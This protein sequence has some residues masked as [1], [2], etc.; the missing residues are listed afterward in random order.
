MKIL[1]VITKSELGGAQSV[2]TNISNYL[3]REHEVTVVAGEGDGRMFDE[4]APNI[5][6]VRCETLVRA[7]SPIKEVKT[8]MFLRKLYRDFR[9]DIIHLHSSK[10]GILG[11]IIFPSAK[12]VYTVHGFDSVRLAFRQFLPVERALR[13]ACKYVVG[14][15]RYDCNNLKAEGIDHNVH[16]VYNG[17]KDCSEGEAQLPFSVPE[18]YQKK[19]VCIARLSPQ[20]N[21]AIFLEVARRMPDVA[22]IW[23]GNLQEAPAH[24]DNVFFWGNIPYSGRL[25]RYFDLFFLPTNYEGLPIVILEAMS[26]GLPVVASDVGGVHEIVHDG[27]NGYTLEN[28]P[29]LFVQKISAIL[30]DDALREKMGAASRKIYLQSHTDKA[31]VESYLR[32]YKE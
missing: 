13:R 16:L 4:L 24:P 6:K 30:S 3:A 22:F 32:L 31:M 7:I 9:P 17:I 19:V 20:K 5:H 11:R 12:I 21:S 15:S 28:D 25:C 23:I 29:D 10:A 18:Q 14:V 1:Q 26:C 8:L 2:V 27:E